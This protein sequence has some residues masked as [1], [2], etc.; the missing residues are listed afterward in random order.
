MVGGEE[1]REAMALQQ[2]EW[3][4]KAPA[5]VTRTALMRLVDLSWS[6][7]HGMSLDAGTHYMP[8]DDPQINLDALATLMARLNALSHLVQH[9]DLGKT[10]L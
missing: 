5:A 3:Q 10:L 7:Y 2:Q 1:G 8:A 6:F 9:T 4:H